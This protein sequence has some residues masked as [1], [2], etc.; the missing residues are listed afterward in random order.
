MRTTYAQHSDLD[1]LGPEGGGVQVV[2]ELGARID[3]LH[4]QITTAKEQSI[5]QQMRAFEPGLEQQACA[6]KV[7]ENIHL[8]TCLNVDLS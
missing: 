1:A 7:G 3:N 2:A 5:H 8:R 4:E 6:G